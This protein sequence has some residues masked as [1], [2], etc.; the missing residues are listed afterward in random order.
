MRRYFSEP[1][2]HSGGTIKVELD[3]SDYARKANLKEATG[4]YTSTLASKADL[5][6][7]KTKIDNLDIEKLKTVTADLSKLNNV[8]V[9]DGVKKPVFDELVNKVNAIDTKILSTSGLATNIKYDWN[10]QGIEEKIEDVDKNITNS[11]AGAKKAVYNTEITETKKKIL[12]AGGLVS[13]AALKT[14]VI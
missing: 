5:D 7:F 10:K 13:T 9:N 12:C 3:L 6:D 4:I 1:Y 11:S 14:K 8:V 2:D